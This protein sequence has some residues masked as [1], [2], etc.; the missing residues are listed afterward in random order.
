MLPPPQPSKLKNSWSQD[1]SQD[2][3]NQYDDSLH[4]AWRPPPPPATL[5]AGDSSHMM[6]PPPQPSKLK[7]S[8]SQ[9]PSQ[10]RPNQYEGSP[11]SAWR[12]WRPS[13]PPAT[14]EAGD[15]SHKMLPPPQPSELKDS[16]LTDGWNQYE[17]WL[18]SPPIKVTAWDSS[19]ELSPPALEDRP[20]QIDSPVL[21][22]RPSQIHPPALEDRPSQID[23]PALEDRPS[24]IHPETLE[25]HPINDAWHRLMSVNVKDMD[26]VST[27]SWPSDS[28]G[29]EE[30][31]AEVADETHLH[32]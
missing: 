4:S 10:D 29:W 32:P 11:H 31:A 26:Q 20:L 19:R 12:A 18:H 16:S 30:D 2:R 13:A 7:N 1:P 5:E 14:L 23:P 3:P 25:A 22:D 8:W 9:D 27:P 24:Q 6:L 17:W 21:E 28:S 15:S